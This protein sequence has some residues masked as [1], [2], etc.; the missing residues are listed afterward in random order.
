M[1]GLL[2]LPMM[3]WGLVCFFRNRRDSF[4]YQWR[5]AFGWLSLCVVP[6]PF[7]AGI[8]KLLKSGEVRDFGVSVLV[9]PLTSPIFLGGHTVITVFE[10]NVKNWTGHRRDTM[11]DNAHVFF[12]LVL[13]QVTVLSLLVA[14]RFQRGKSWRDPWVLCVGVFMMVNAFLAKDW[15][16]YG[17]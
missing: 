3:V 2:F 7:V 16:W 1:Y 14:W 6:I 10:D 11:F 4:L 17:T 12:A 5:R 8:L 13:I 15:P 9:A